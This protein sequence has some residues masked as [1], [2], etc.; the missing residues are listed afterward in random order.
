MCNVSVLNLSFL[1]AVIVGFSP[2]VYTVPEGEERN[3]TI[4][5]VGESSVAVSVLISTIDGTAMSTLNSLNNNYKSGDLIVFIFHAAPMDY[6]SISTQNVTFAPNQ[7]EQF[8]L[9]RTFPDST[10]EGR[11]TLSAV[12]TDASEGVTIG[13]GIANITIT[14]DTCKSSFVLNEFC[15]EL[16]QSITLQW[17]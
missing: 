6:T 15:K 16:T 17:W 7:S 9:L 8:V 11:E 14:E 1:S 5:K 10:V 4:V 2:A 12:L 3:L 13:Q